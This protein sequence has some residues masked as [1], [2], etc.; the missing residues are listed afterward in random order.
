M[1]G[2]F[3][4]SKTKRHVTSQKLPT[5]ENGTSPQIALLRLTLYLKI[6][7]ASTLPYNGTQSPPLQGVSSP[8]NCPT[9]LTNLRLVGRLGIREWLGV[10]VKADADDVFSGGAKHFNG[11]KKK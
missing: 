6:R 9:I 4:P 7:P 3:S 1:N 8:V 2:H 5:P 11:V 10:W